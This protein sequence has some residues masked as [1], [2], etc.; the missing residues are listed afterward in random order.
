MLLLFRPQIEGLLLQRD[1]V[2]DKWDRA[3]P[4][5]SVLD[6]ED[7]E[8]TSSTHIDIDDQIARIAEAR[9]SA[10]RIRKVRK[11]GPGSP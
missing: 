6:D 5:R 10:A 2:L 3:H 11:N 7:L 4:S 1:D 9:R 8:I